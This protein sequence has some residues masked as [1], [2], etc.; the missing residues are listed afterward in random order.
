[1]AR[2]CG[3]R[4]SQMNTRRSLVILSI[5]LAAA[6]LI[7]SPFLPGPANGIVNM[8]FNLGQILGLLGLVIIPV[9][10]IWVISDLRKKRNDLTHRVH[11]TAILLLT[12]PLTIFVTSIYISEMTRDFSRGYAIDR[13]TEL[14]E[15]IEKFRQAKGHYPETLTTLSPEFISKI[16][17]TGIMGIDQFQYEKRGDTYNLSFQQNVILGFNF[18]VV[19]FDPTDAHQAQGELADVYETGRTH[20]RYYIYD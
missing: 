6:L 1:M 14:V 8:L 4:L 5:N 13:T 10:A 2:Q 15:G 12:L 19:T 20:W 11:P 16:P 7:L 17:S 9:G 18:E 3:A